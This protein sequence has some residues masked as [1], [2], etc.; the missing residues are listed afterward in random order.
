MEVLIGTPTYEKQ[1]SVDYNLSSVQTA[2][3]LTA[4]RIVMHQHVIAGNCFI[5]LARNEIVEHFL[6]HTKAENLLFVDAD[7]GWDAKAVTRVL[8]HKQE[9]VAGLVPKRDSENGAMY[10]MNAL[11]GVVEDG[12]F[13][14]KE[15]PTAFMRIKRSAFEKLK[16]PYFKTGSTPEDH[17]EDIYFCRRWCE[18]GEHLWIDSDISFSHRGSRVWKGNFY[19]HC[20]AQ[21]LLQTH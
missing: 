10:H 14:A 5:D 21:G 4:R 8:M 11:T 6:M 9:V 13:Q 2:I 20:V 7:V 12:L 16:K 17:G 3:E 15:A 18:L 19:E 1:V